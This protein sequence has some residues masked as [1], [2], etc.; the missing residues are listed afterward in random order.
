MDDKFRSRKWM[1]TVAVQ[2]TATIALFTHFIDG[3]QFATISSANVVQYGFTNA[4]QYFA[5]R[6]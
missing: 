4:A 6:G 1:L 5:E 3:A 2:T